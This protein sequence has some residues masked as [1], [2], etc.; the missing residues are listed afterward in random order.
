MHQTSYAEM[1]A[2]FDRYF[3]TYKENVINIVDLGSMDING[4]Y[5]PLIPPNW[6]YVGVD[7]APGR[8]VDLIMP[9]KYIIPIAENSVEILISGQCFEHVDKPWE[10]IKDVYRVLSPSG[11]CVITAPAKCAIH[12]Y[13]KDYWRFYPDGMR[14]ILESA[15]FRVIEAYALPKDGLNGEGEHYNKPGSMV[16]CWGI[17]V[18]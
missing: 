11:M 10:L 13:P 14:V 18:K 2:V 8:N 15:G 12:E 17:G 3:K 5:K 7:I 4:S 6:K 9:S 1:S 16:D